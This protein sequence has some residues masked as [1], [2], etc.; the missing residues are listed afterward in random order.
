MID[1]LKRSNYYLF[2]FIKDK[3]SNKEHKTKTENESDHNKTEYKNIEEVQIA[4]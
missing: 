4:G 2:D 1:E 3:L